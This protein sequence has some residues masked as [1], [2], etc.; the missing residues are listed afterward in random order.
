MEILIVDSSTEISSRLKE[1]LFEVVTI[2][3]I[4]E[5]NTYSDAIEA[6]RKIKPAIIIMDISLPQKKPLE[7]IKKIKAFQKK[8]VIIAL[9]NSDENL[10]RL[11][12]KQAG[13][14]YFFD[15]Y[16]E[17]EKVAETIRSMNEKE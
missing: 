12:Y 16:H 4:H 14:A 9:S 11:Q 15:K 13:V 8:I 6:T 7:A 3:A 5:V 17:F 10:D 1:L 2:K